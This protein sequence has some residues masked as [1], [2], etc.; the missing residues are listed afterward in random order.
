MEHQIEPQI[1]EQVENWCI[2][3]KM[4]VVRHLLWNA[5]LEWV[6]D[7]ARSAL[8]A[9]YQ[10]TNKDSKELSCM[11]IYRHIS[12]DY[13]KEIRNTINEILETKANDPF[14]D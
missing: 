13:L 2:H 3:C 5:E 14:S 11:G 9:I 12:P 6:S 10:R 4:Q 7:M 8:E 1:L